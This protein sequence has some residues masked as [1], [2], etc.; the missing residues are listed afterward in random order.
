MAEFSDNEY[1]KAEKRKHAAFKH[2]VHQNNLHYT[3]FGLQLIRE[4]GISYLHETLPGLY[5]R[6]IQE[7]FK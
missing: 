7:L 3:K 1:K 2:Y 6:K 5:G 4:E